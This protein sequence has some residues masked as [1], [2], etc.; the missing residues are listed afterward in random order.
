MPL[1]KL[2]IAPG[3]YTEATDKDRRPKWKDGNRIRFRYGYP[4]SIGGWQKDST[5]TFKGVCR[6]INNWVTLSEEVLIGLG[7]HKRLLIWR[8][9]TF[10]NVTPLRTSTKSPF[11]ATPV[12]DIFSTTAASA[13]VAVLQVTHGV[14]VGDG[15]FFTN[16]TAS[17]IDGTVIPT[18]EIEVTEVTDADNYSFELSSTVT[19]TEASWGSA[20]QV[21][22]GGFGAD[23]N[24]TKG[25][26]WSIAAGVASSD[27]TQVANSDLSQAITPTSGET[28][29]VTFTVSNYSAGNV[30][31]VIGDVEGT[32]RAANGTFVETI[33]SSSGTD[34]DIRADLNFVGDI[35][36]VI[37]KP[38]VGF[39]YEINVGEEDTSSL[40]GWGA[41][42][43]SEDE[44][45]TARTSGGISQFA[46]VWHLDQFGEDLVANIHG[47]AIYTWDA[48]NGTTTRAIVIS[49]APATARFILTSPQAR[50][51]IAFGA[52]DGSVD[53]PLLIR[54]SDSEDFTDFTPTNINLAGDLR[55]DRG[56]ELVGGVRTR[57]QILALT[58]VSAHSFFHT[59]DSFVFAID[60][61]GEGC[62][63]IA[64]HAILEHSGVVLY[65]GLDNFYIYDGVVR[66][67]PCDVWSFVYDDINI[68]Q[69]R[70][71]HAATNRKFNEGWFFYCSAA[72]DEIDRYVKINYLD[73]V[74]DYGALDRTAW[75]DIAEGGGLTVPY[76]PDASGILYQHEVGVDD[77]ISALGS[78]IESFD[79]DIEEGGVLYHIKKLLPDFIQLTGNVTV[80]L[81]AKLYPQSTA[82]SKGP[83]TVTSST[84]RISTRVRGRQ[85]S[86]NITSSTI[87]DAW[88]MG[89]F[90]AQIVPHGKR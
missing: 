70:K 31:P 18:T 65:Q 55:I 27:G 34:L 88:Q 72:S 8:G 40:L 58:D 51:L 78:R 59:N 43:W 71:F 86:L 30:T 75:I 50:H 73:Q 3:V 35:D 62:G 29:E 53:D 45:G 19:T 20:D 41:G 32:D 81:K 4:E 33:V 26:G 28:Y 60:I 63:L 46:R 22:N 38:H 82:V 9:G 85:I 49:G 2:S 14:K 56:T 37:V 39:S 47:G 13:T 79:F 23:T 89:T 57:G 74:W 36:D 21:T 17:P 68:A 48:T 7:T 84:E 1:V 5:N 69:K 77:D 66:V 25:T 15:I 90:Q 54:W 64:P 44:W 67:L 87:G 10:F 11:S 16:Q 24:W 52:H 76:A 80:D 42:T 61:L 6:G 83:Y 12:E